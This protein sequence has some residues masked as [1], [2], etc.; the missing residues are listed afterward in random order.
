MFKVFFVCLNS[1]LKV[2]SHDT[3]S[4]QLSHLNFPFQQ[5]VVSCESKSWMTKLQL[6][7]RFKMD[8]YPYSIQ[9][10]Y[11]VWESYL[12]RGKR[13]LNCI[14]NELKVKLGYLT[15]QIQIQILSLC[16]NCFTYLPE[17]QI[18]KKIIFIQTNSFIIFT[19]PNP[20]F[21]VSGFGQ[22]G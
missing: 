4:C 2:W 3:I 9:Q 15:Y 11:N 17:T 12:D 20:V 10:S 14:K 7:H 16:L 22:E 5:K 1:C 18:K 6:K 13:N 8:W 21:F 19:C